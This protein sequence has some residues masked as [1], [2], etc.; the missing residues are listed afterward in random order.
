MA[1]RDPLQASTQW[2]TLHRSVSRF[3]LAGTAEQV[4]S[5]FPTKEAD[6][7]RTWRQIRSAGCCELLSGHDD[8]CPLTTTSTMGSKEFD[9]SLRPRRMPRA[10]DANPDIPDLEYRQCRHENRRRNR[11]VP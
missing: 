5:T 6:R 3:V 8:R 10:P 9:L 1:T 11:L 2:L 7:T 4:F